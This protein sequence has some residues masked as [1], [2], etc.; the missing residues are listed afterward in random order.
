MP[1][2]DG[3][4]ERSIRRWVCEWN[5]REDVAGGSMTS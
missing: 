4:G 3:G 1:Q 2:S 5:Q